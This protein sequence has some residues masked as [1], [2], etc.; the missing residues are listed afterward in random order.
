MVGMAAG[1]PF[2]RPRPYLKGVRGDGV[3]QRE[4]S[5]TRRSV[6]ATVSGE[7]RPGIAVGDLLFIGR[8]ASV[9]FDGDRAL[10]L[11]VTSL[12]PRPTYEGWV[13]LTGYVL[14]EHGAAVERREVY[15][16]RAGVRR[17]AARTDSARYVSDRTT[18]RAAP[19]QPPVRPTPDQIP[20]RLVPDQGPARPGPSHATA[21]SGA[22]RVARR[23]RVGR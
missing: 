18:V 19:D 16:Q 2:R 6:V 21:R 22:V 7:V 17:V 11:R 5:G 3:G 12:D 13:W 9:Q 1:S 8:E 4:V 20:V 14:D 15:V 23:Q 10:W